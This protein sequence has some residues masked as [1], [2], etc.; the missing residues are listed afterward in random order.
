MKYGIHKPKWH[1]R[2]MKPVKN[3]GKAK[4]KPK[5]KSKRASNEE[6]DWVATFPMT[7]IPWPPVSQ[8]EP[9]PERDA[10]GFWILKRKGGGT[11]GV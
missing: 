10:E 6:D 8:V 3:K 4:S 2:W 9:L 5:R 7:V 11:D 1:I